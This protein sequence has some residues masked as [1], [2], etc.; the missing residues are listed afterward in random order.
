MKISAWHKQNGDDVVLKTDYN[1]LDQFDKVYISKVFTDTVIPC[2]PED[3]SGK[4]DT[5]ISEWY[6]DNELLNRPNVVFGGTGFYYDKAPPLPQEIEHIMPDYHLY[7]EWV[8]D[9]LSSGA[10]KKDTQYYTD[11][12]IGFT[13]RGCFRRCSFCVNRNYDRCFLHSPIEE[14]FDKNRRYICLLDDNVFSCSEWAS[15]FKNL[16]ATKKRFQFKQGLDIR[17]ITDEK[18]DALLKSR[19]ID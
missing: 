9:K 7:D 19:W 12:S 10:S 11:F 5:N 3:K 6:S 14:F 18:C 2:E 4:G 15:V 1:S 13:T 8:S 16:Q 17:L